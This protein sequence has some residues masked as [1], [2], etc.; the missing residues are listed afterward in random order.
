MTDR[1]MLR[2]FLAV[3]EAG[4]FSRAAKRVGVSQPSL[5]AG[6]A[7]LE[8]QLG[9]RLFDRDKH[10][11]A[12]TPAGSRFL[13][14]ARRISAE[15]ELALQDVQQAPE[16]SVLRVGVLG[17]IPTATVEAILARHRRLGGS[18]A[19]DMLDGSERDLAE[20]LDR[21]RL[22]VALTVVRPHH[23]RFSPELLRGERYLMVLPRDH[24]LAEGDFVEAEQ[25]AGDRMVVRRHCEAL[26]EIDR[27]F[28]ERGVRPRFVLKTTSDQR[29]LAVVRAGLGV[30]MMPESFQ[31]P[32][33]R[34]VRVKDF[35]LQREVGLLYAPGRESLRYGAS[36]FL[37]LVREQ[38]GRA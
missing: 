22:D 33:V 32:L 30:G 29:V 26:P 24:V 11:V 13:V 28:T 35:D 20:R 38:Y 4:N 9:V 17:T 18:E 6:V 3:A 34:F 23:A 12:L 5:S 2:Y 31:D 19:L 10:H 36:P 16:P 1:Y 27:F 7:K 21:G 37:S 25:L 15:Y 8:S 14:R